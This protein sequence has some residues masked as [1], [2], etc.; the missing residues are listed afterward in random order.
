[1]EVCSFYIG[2]KAGT[3]HLLK[4]EASESKTEPFPICE[5]RGTAHIRRQVIRSE[6]VIYC[7]NIAMEFLRKTDYVQTEMKKLQVRGGDRI[8]TCAHPSDLLY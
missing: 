5:R 4:Q 3:T 7:Q 1:M 2:R 8:F 6:E